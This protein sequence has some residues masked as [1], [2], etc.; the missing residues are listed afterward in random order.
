MACVIEKMI[1]IE[2]ILREQNIEALEYAIEK[3]L[4]ISNIRLLA[5]LDMINEPNFNFLELLIKNGVDIN[6]EGSKSDTKFMFS[7]MEKSLEDNRHLWFETQKENEEWSSFFCKYIDK[8]RNISQYNLNENGFMPHNIIIEFFFNHLKKELK[9][10]KLSL[11]DTKN[12]YI[13]IETYYR[14]STLIF[15]IY[16]NNFKL[17]KF[18]IKHG[19]DVHM[20]D[21]FEGNTPL[22]YA[23]FGCYLDS[24][25]AIYNIE[26][27]E[28]LIKNRADVNQPNFQGVRPLTFA[29]ESFAHVEVIKTLIKYGASVDDYSDL[30]FKK[31]Y[32]KKFGKYIHEDKQYEL[33]ISDRISLLMRATETKYYESIKVLIDNNVQLDLQDGH[34]NTALIV[35]SSNGLYDIAKLLVEA[36]ASIEIKNNHGKNAID[37]ANEKIK[38]M[39]LENLKV[40][41]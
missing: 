30:N 39:L 25:D 10:S 38:K 1:N 32:L 15:A 24:K 27:I 18:L 28:Y 33:K 14:Y 6:S 34:G 20:Y 19:A 40:G 23:V 17:V 11:E 21:Y 4:D 36:G 26:T 41:K 8:T 13:K 5:V 12:R 37:Y 31:N 35:V 7:I 2:K 3:G 22:H 16:K 29:I 9:S